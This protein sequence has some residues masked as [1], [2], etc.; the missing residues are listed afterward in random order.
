MKFSK[1]IYLAVAISL[2]TGVAPTAA[3]ILFPENTSDSYWLPKNNE[4]SDKVAWVSMHMKSFISLAGKDGKLDE[5]DLARQRKA[6]EERTELRSALSF[7]SVDHNL[8]ETVTLAEMETFDFSDEA[9]SENLGKRFARFDKNNDGNISRQEWRDEAIREQAERDKENHDYTAYDF[10]R[11]WG[12]NPSQRKVTTSAEYEIALG[13]L[14]DHYDKDK[15]GLLSE[16][17]ADVWQKAVMTRGLIELFEQYPELR[18]D[19]EAVK[20]VEGLKKLIGVSAQ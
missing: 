6:S 7:L 19:P 18:D 15:D 9:Q 4:P 17:E 14:Y 1:L 13:R 2:L 10:A 8:D 12:V 5:D 16:A 20:R 11:Y 3:D